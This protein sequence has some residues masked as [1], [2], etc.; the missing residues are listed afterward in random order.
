MQSFYATD[1]I[2]SS[3][4]KSKK[5]EEI[6]ILGIQIFLLFVSYFFLLTFFVV[7]GH[8]VNSIICDTLVRHYEYSPQSFSI[9]IFSRLKIYP[10][11]SLV[12]QTL[13]FYWFYLYGL[14]KKTSFWIITSFIFNLAWLNYT[15]NK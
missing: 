6:L 4:K 14:R 7:M 5:S 11:L 3:K 15:Q 2:L 12:K 10:K 13:I 1:R 8:V 9:E